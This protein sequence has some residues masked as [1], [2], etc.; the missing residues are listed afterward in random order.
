M[1]VSWRGAIILFLYVGPLLDLKFDFPAS[2]GETPAGLKENIVQVLMAA[3][4]L[5]HDS[6]SPHQLSQCCF[7]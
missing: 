7:I 1:D 4:G 3:L 2:S 6:H 5:Q